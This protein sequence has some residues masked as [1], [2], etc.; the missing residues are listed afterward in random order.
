MKIRV[1]IVED[2][3]ETREGLKAMIAA[4]TE[5][6]C[7]GEFEDAESLIERQLYLRT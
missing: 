3:S 2:N 6:T 5:F 7:T 4:S 1:A